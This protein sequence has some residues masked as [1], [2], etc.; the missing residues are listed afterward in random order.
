[1][2]KF[3][4][5]ILSHEISSSNSILS[6]Y[7]SVSSSNFFFNLQTVK[8]NCWKSIKIFLIHSYKSI[9]SA[10]SKITP[11]GI[12]TN[13]KSNSTLS[14][15]NIK[16]AFFRSSPYLFLR[17]VKFF[18]Q[19][20]LSRRMKSLKCHWRLQFNIKWN[21]LLARRFLYFISRLLCWMFSSSYILR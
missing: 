21:I 7:S 1:M 17:Q 2:R 16:H 15:G 18:L 3:Q 4:T 19:V 20:E 14:G 5:W 12:D 9:K 8:M 11:I 6:S 10:N 13:K